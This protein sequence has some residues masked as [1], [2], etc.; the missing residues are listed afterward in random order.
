MYPFGLLRD[1][2]GG[3][4]PE[5]WPQ[6]RG[7]GRRRAR[8]LARWRGRRE[9]HLAQRTIPGKPDP[10]QTR[11]TRRLNAELAQ[12]HERRRPWPGWGR[13]CVCGGRYV[14]RVLEA[15]VVAIIGGGAL[16]LASRFGVARPFKNPRDDI[17]RDQRILRRLG[18]A[19]P[20][21]DP[22]AESIDRRVIELITQSGDL[23]RNWVGIVLGTVFLAAF[24]WLAW[25]FGTWG[26][27]WWSAAV[28]SGIVSAAMLTV[29]PQEW[30]KRRRNKAGQAI[31]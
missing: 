19:S 12:P 6:P 24:G 1:G 13:R 9:W 30:Q 23:R 14:A 11:E 7:R 28:L 26:G 2:N 8:V 10:A 5:I 4:H 15:V 31:D 29:I 22:L 3:L 17:D 27:W 21:R 25:R 16:V 20:A 18:E